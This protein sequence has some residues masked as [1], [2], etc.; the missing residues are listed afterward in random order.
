[1][2]H[3]PSRRYPRRADT[4][5]TRN[6]HRPPAEGEHVPRSWLRGVF[7]PLTVAVTVALVLG[8]LLPAPGSWLPT[9]MVVAKVAIGF[10]FF[11][12]GIRISTSDIIAGVNH[13]RMH[14]TILVI[15][16]VIFPIIGW[17]MQFL[18]SIMLRPELHAGVIFM[19]LVPSTVQASISFTAIAGGNVPAA[20]I[21]ATLS[22]LVGV[23]ATPLLTYLLLSPAGDVTINAATARDLVLSLVLP[24]I[25]GQLVRP[26]VKAWVDSHESTL[27][28]VGRESIMLVVYAAFSTAQ[29]QHFWKRLDWW[30]ILQML[31]MSVTVLLV[32]LPLSRWIAVRLGF[33]RGDAIAIQ[34]CGSKKA[35]ATGLP[36][37]TILFSGN[38]LGLV[39]VPLIIFHQVQLVGCSWLANHYARQLRSATA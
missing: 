11:L 39:M 31:A 29:D 1:M 35:L 21:G 15:T 22:N 2:A 4:L 10:L 27:R 38:A 9:V 17:V 23:I 37:A 12:N 20:I 24:F 7:D 32:I 3:R 14:L 8:L 36:I 33:D 19:C 13:W 25:L 6:L 5:R 16:F 18:P 30:E 26:R 28:N 34:F